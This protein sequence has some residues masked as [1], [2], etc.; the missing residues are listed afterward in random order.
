MYIWFNTTKL[1]QEMNKMT[2]ETHN[3]FQN[4]FG[5]NFLPSQNGNVHSTT[6]KALQFAN[7]STVKIHKLIK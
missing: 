5:T 1:T 4:A 3:I 7:L 6:C 2:F